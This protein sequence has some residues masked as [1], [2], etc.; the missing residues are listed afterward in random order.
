[1]NQTDT[2]KAKLNRGEKHNH[3]VPYFGYSRKEPNKAPPMHIGSRVWIA[4]THFTVTSPKKN[5]GKTKN[6]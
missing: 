2:L 6:S 4:S 3:Q 5:K 1:M